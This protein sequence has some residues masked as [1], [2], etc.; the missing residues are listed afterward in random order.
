MKLPSPTRR[1]PFWF[2]AQMILRVVFAVWFRYQTKGHEVVP[3]EGGGLIVSNHESHLDPLLVGIPFNRPVSYVV[4]ESL[5]KVP[6]VGLIIKHNYSIPISRSATSGASIRTACQYLEHGFLMGVFPEGTRSADGVI[7]KFRPG[8]VTLAK[9]SKLPVYTCGIAGAHSAMPRGSW[10]IRP[11][12]IVVVYGEP[13]SV[14]EIAELIEQGREKEL[15]QM[16]ED[17]V[18]ACKREAEAIINGVK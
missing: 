15:A 9:R 1:N 16:A 18:K 4:R 14:E 2:S 17:R 11:R 10:F 12:K 5:W 3:N 13:F 6:V 7:A 8:F